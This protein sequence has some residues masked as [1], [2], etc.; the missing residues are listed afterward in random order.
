[1]E[2]KNMFVKPYEFAKAVTD[3]MIILLDELEKTRDVKKEIELLEGLITQY[4]ISI[5]FSL[6]ENQFILDGEVVDETTF[7]TV[8]KATDKELEWFYGIRLSKLRIK[9]LKNNA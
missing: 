5:E 1:M 3:R 8:R 9:E 4:E 6:D 2:K 7:E